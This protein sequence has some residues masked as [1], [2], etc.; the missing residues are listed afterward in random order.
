MMDTNCYINMFPSP[1]IC[2]QLSV[3]TGDCW[4]DG[5]H[6]CAKTNVCVSSCLL[7][8]CFSVGLEITLWT[9]THSNHDD[10]ITSSAAPPNDAASFLPLL[11]LP[12][13]HLKND[14]K[15][16]CLSDEWGGSAGCF[17]LIDWS[18]L[19]CPQSCVQQ[20]RRSVQVLMETPV[21]ELLPTAEGQH[22]EGLGQLRLNPAVNQSAGLRPVTSLTC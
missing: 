1:H 17:W 4:Q 2:L 21:S 22:V 3:C 10:V 12:T 16:V 9:Q 7:A 19:L 5:P 14:Q 15:H 6:V 13:M 20:V 18:G 11:V 8:V